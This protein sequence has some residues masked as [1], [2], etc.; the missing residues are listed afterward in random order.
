MYASDAEHS[1][2]LGQ[3]V[4]YSLAIPLGKTSG[5]DD[6]LEIT[7]L[8]KP[9]DIDDVVNR[10]LLRALNES[11]SVYY[12]YVRV[13]V[14]GYDLESRVIKLVKH[15]FGIKLILRTPQRNK[16]DFYHIF[17]LMG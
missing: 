12:N 15:D 11:A 10:L 5:H 8:L 14:L 6:S 13:N 9:A 16:P 1:V 2:Y 3:L 4:E 7:I 17:S